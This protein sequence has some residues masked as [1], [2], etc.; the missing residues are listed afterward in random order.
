MNRSIQIRAHGAFRSFSAVPFVITIV[1]AAACSSGGDDN[2]SQQGTITGDGSMQP[3]MNGAT[4]NNPGTGMNPIGGNTGNNGGTTGQEPDSPNAG[5]AMPC[6]VS[7]VV[8]SSCQTCHGATPLGGAPMSLLTV[9]DFTRD[10]V[11][12]TTKPLMGQTFK[13]YELARIRINGEMGTTP[14]PQG[15][16]L[17]AEDKST[18]NNWLT[19]MAPVGMACTGTQ[20]MKPPMN[21]NP[22]GMAG[23]GGVDDGMGD[24]PTS[25]ATNSQCDL[26]GSRDHLTEKPGETC[27]DFLVHGQSG[28]DDTSKFTIPLDETYNQFY[29]AVPWPAG[30]VATRYGGDYDNLPVLH[31][32]L[33]FSSIS[34]NPPGTVT[35]GVTG[36]TL[37]ENAELIAGWAIGGC[38]TDYGDDV[39]VMLPDDGDI[40]IQWHHFNS[41]GTPQQDGSKVR[42]CTVPKDARKNIAGITFLGT[43]AIAI[44][45]GGDTSLSSTCTNNTMGPIT[46]LGFTPHMHTIGSRMTSVVTRAGSGKTETVFDKPFVFDQQ[47]NYKQDP[48]LVLNPG[49]TIESTCTWTNNSDG[50]VTFGQSTHD[51]MCY[52]FTLSYPYG[53]LNDGVISLIGATNTCW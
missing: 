45:P 29:Y 43:E 27:Y 44:A 17:A 3:S 10:Y 42:I 53:A 30:S 7:T 38:N 36:T 25:M 35:P 20:M 1:A 14:M 6:D 34:T 4:G 2:K 39:G 28:A 49:D 15:R 40:M 9:A 37:G 23:S 31:H 12:K 46:I 19:A 16:E 52:Q 50:V 21:G 51:E 11:A 32:W 33:A 26:P 5:G 48:L 8:K 47:V 41:T 13:M 18:L 22:M 24:G